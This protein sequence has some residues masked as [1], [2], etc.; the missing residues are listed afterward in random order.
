MLA[1]YLNTPFKIN[2]NYRPLSAFYF[3]HRPFFHVVRSIPKMIAHLMSLQETP[4]PKMMAAWSQWVEHLQSYDAFLSQV[5]KILQA[6]DCDYPQVSC[7]SQFDASYYDIAYRYNDHAQP[8]GLIL[9]E[10]ELKSLWLSGFWSA[11]QLLQEDLICYL[12]I[13]HLSHLYPI[14]PSEHPFLPEDTNH[15]IRHQVWLAGA[16]ALFDVLSKLVLP[17]Q[18][19]FETIAEQE[20]ITLYHQYDDPKI[21]THLIQQMN[22]PVRALLLSDNMV[23]HLSKH[24]PPD[25]LKIDFANLENQDLLLEKV[26]SNYETWLKLISENQKGKMEC[27]FDMVRTI[28]KQVSH[29]HHSPLWSEHFPFYTQ[30]DL[31]FACDWV[32]Y[33]PNVQAALGV[34]AQDWAN[35]FGSYLYQHQTHP[36]SIA[37]FLLFEDRPALMKWVLIV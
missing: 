33:P 13:H 10:T 1:Y 31:K 30:D 23:F 6:H 17:K 29:Q 2:L 3:S 12:N 22:H 4:Q 11:Y 18:F 32:F 35:H 37:S 20:N 15:E 28:L 26:H 16:Y 8:Y 24:F 36:N 7:L 21:E 34:Q 9:P 19:L 25:R 5:G 27:L 14:I